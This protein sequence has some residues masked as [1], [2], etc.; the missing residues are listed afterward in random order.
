MSSRATTGAV[1]KRKKDTTGTK[2]SPNAMERLLEEAQGEELPNRNNLNLEGEG[3]ATAQYE[4]NQ[5][6]ADNTDEEL[7]NPVTS[8]SVSGREE[9]R[10]SERKDANDYESSNEDMLD[11]DSQETTDSDNDS[12]HSSSNS[13]NTEVDEPGLL[14][15]F[16][17]LNLGRDEKKEKKKEV[18]MGNRDPADIDW[19][20]G[21]GLSSFCIFRTGPPQ[22]PRYEFHRTNAYVF[23]EPREIYQCSNRISQL[24]WTDAQGKKHYDYNKENIRGTVGIAVEERYGNKIY[25]NCPPVWVKIRWQGIQKKHQKFLVREHSWIPKCDVIRMLG[26]KQ[27][28]VRLHAAWDL[29]ESRYTQAMGEK[30]KFIDPLDYPINLFNEIKIE[31]ERSRSQSVM[32]P[33]L[34]TPGRLQSA[35]PM[36]GH[37]RRGPT[38]GASR[39]IKEEEDEQYAQRVAPSHSPA[40]TGEAHIADRE[41]SEKAGNKRQTKRTFNM[42]D[43]MATME[44]A[45]NWHAL[46]ESDKEMKFITALAKYD[47]YKQ[48]R[49]DMG[50]EEEE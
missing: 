24:G 23:P 30:G 27:A 35:A 4:D 5:Q 49:L 42:K 18:Q 47:H 10:D 34:M 3:S 50:D 40:Q 16:T 43:F 21:E 25:V 8:V 46:S 48:V 41:G 36:G 6:F 14:E 15:D 26:V 20:G 39:I 17:K 44:K 11:S 22:A 45:E 29:Q 37:G 9:E 19:Y 12:T 28:P 13:T 33:S 2:R 7:P 38:A 1:Q 31:R 32:P